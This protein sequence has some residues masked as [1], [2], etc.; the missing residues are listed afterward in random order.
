MNKFQIARNNF[1]RSVLLSE[2]WGEIGL[3]NQKPCRDINLTVRYAQPNLQHE[4]QRYFELLFM[5]VITVY[6]LIYLLNSICGITPSHSIVSEF[7]QLSL[8]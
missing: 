4:G 1:K 7:L 5:I 8:Y 6:I 2:S 3:M